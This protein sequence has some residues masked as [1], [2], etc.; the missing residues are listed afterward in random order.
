MAKGAPSTLSHERVRVH[1]SSPRY[2]LPMLE[3]RLDKSLRVLL[4]NAIRGS[5]ALL[6][7]LALAFLFCFPLLQTYISRWEHFISPTV[8]AARIEAVTPCDEPACVVVTLSYYPPDGRLQRAE[9][10]YRLP[11]SG[12]G[13][14][15]A[16]RSVSGWLEDV[17][18]EVNSLLGGLAREAPQRKWG[19]EEVVD[20]PA[21]PAQ[22][23]LSSSV[24]DLSGLAM[25]V[26][27]LSLQRT[28]VGPEI[29]M[30]FSWLLPYPG[31]SVLVQHFP[32]GAPW[33]Y[34]PLGVHL[35]VLAN[36]ALVTALAFGLAARWLYHP[37][38]AAHGRMNYVWRLAR[39][40]GER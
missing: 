37:I 17:Q 20:I 39:Q 34:F 35:W 8:T 7:G 31:G 1:P 26:E 22:G 16:A 10:S 28:S 3:D 40:E 29:P 25:V 27:Y 32:V 30:R 23:E 13:L 12:D 4:W 11:W 21:Q 2:N 19:S 6:V 15:S 33:L 9:M 36:S 24:E 18:R 14:L 38:L 5:F